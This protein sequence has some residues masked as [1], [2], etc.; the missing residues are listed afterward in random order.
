MSHMIRE[1][2]SRYLTLL[3]Y[4]FERLLSIQFNSNFDPGLSPGSNLSNYNS[5]SRSIQHIL[6]LQTNTPALLLHLHFP[7]LS[8]LSS[9]PLSLH[10]IPGI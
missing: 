2:S 7:C 5:L 6:L 4:F 10:L 3:Q 1:H 8:R 9:L